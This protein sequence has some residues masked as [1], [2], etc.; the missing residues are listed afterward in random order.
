[1]LAHRRVLRH[2]H[3]LC[4]TLGDEV[5]NAE[6]GPTLLNP[7]IIPLTRAPRILHVA[8]RLELVLKMLPIALIPLSDRTVDI[9]GK[10]VRDPDLIVGSLY[11]ALAIAAVFGLTRIDS[12]PTAHV[13]TSGNTV[14]RA[15]P[16]DA[17][18]HLDVNG[19]ARDT[20][21]ATSH[22]PA[23]LREHQD[24][25]GRGGST[26]P[27]HRSPTAERGAGPHGLFNRMGAVTQ[28]W[29]RRPVVLLLAPIQ[30]AFGVSAA[31]LGYQVTGK[32]VKESFG[33]HALVVGSLLSA[34]V[35]LSAAI[36]QPVS[37]YLSPRLGKPPIML[38]GL[39]AFVGLATLVHFSPAQLAAPA[40]LVV[41][42]FY[43]LQGVGRAC[44]EGT[45]KALYADIFGA[46]DSPA[47]FSN[48]VLAN[49]LAS[50]AAY[51]AFPKLSKQEMA[52]VA[53]VCS[54]IAVGGYLVAEVVHRTQNF[55]G[56]GRE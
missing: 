19:E 48:I 7:I 2:G 26:I 35:S 12:L 14:H 23:S 17:E 34:L 29:S 40:G 32:M 37:R 53:L 46:N 11:S 51:F 27:R 36:L 24:E 15:D 3:L 45:N 52:T 30:V 55:R 16:S 44:Y 13:S 18:C 25:L 6:V 21:P 10:P 47:A 42:P 31:L 28:L 39:L 41:L 50:S 1:M 33:S 22:L 9:F 56:G 20:S 54:L 8:L 43:L 38:A 5:P 49:G 4:D